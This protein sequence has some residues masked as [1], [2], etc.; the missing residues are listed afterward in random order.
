MYTFFSW[1]HEGDAS[2][3]DG[4]GRDEV[5]TE[6]AALDLSGTGPTFGPVNMHLRPGIRSL[7]EIEEQVNNNP[8]KLDIPPFTVAGS[9][10]SFFDVFCEIE[11]GGQVF[12]NVQP[13]RWYDLINYKPPK[14]ASYES[15]PQPISLVDEDGNPTGFYIGPSLY[16]PGYCGPIPIGDLNQDCT[17]NFFDF[18]IFA[19]H[20]LECTRVICP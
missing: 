11:I 9:A 17:V 18:A 20:W 2:D 16:R 5:D 6:M 12:H 10:D 15:N 14:N 3:G 8:G 1:V 13:L 4:D 19:S 7:G